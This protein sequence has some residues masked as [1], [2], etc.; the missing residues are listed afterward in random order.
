MPHPRSETGRLLTF[1]VIEKLRS[2]ELGRNI[3]ANQHE[4]ELQRQGLE[5]RIRD[6]TQIIA[7]L[8]TQLKG[9]PKFIFEL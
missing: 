5:E 6:C 4:A 2:D 7:D 1:A 8:R 3:F 9:G